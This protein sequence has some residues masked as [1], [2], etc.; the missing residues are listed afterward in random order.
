MR[1]FY[2]DFSRTSDFQ[3]CLAYPID[4]VRKRPTCGASYCEY[5]STVQYSQ[6]SAF[7]S[8]YF[9]G[10]GVLLDSFFL[11]FLIKSCFFMIKR[12][13]Y[14]ARAQ[15]RLVSGITGKDDGIGPEPG[16]VRGGA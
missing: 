10:L 14:P 12:C 15:K 4:S 5:R 1:Y 7:C 6:V 2:K 9:L 3:S 16:P 8:F 13:S 11:I